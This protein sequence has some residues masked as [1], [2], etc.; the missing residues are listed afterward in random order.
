MK[1]CRI[2]GESLNKP[3]YTS[4]SPSITSVRSLSDTQIF[5]YLC[6]KCLHAQKPVLNNN[7]HY[8]DKEYK[9]SLESNDFDQ[10]YD[11]IEDNIIYRTDYQAKLVIDF[12]D[13]PHNAKVLDYGAGKATTLRK[14]LEIRPD[15]IPYIFDV[16]DKYKE[17][18]QEF[19]PKEQQSTYNIPKSWEKKFSLITA[20]FV[21]EH[22]EDPIFLLNKLTKLLTKDGFIFF[23]VPNLLTNPGDFLAVDHINH[24]STASIYKALKSAKLELVKINKNIFRGAILCI[25]KYR[26][27]HNT[28]PQNETEYFTQDIENVVRYWKYF[29][30]KLKIL[31]KKHTNIP[32]AIFGAGVYGSYIAARIKD[33]TSL[34]CFLDNSDHLINSNHMGVP[35][36]SPQNIPEDI[37]VIYSGIN[38]SISRSVFGK[39]KNSGKYKIIFFDEGATEND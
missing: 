29:D 27:D 2:C 16:S 22:T 23:T 26:D 15:I 19:T 7:F 9:I 20:H 36:I 5:V 4:Q 12:I 6:P 21:F 24:F 30:K 33:N 37:Q 25:A 39:L 18:W 3:I 28:H 32:T 10:L 17:T 1:T 8:Y 34:K 14:I 31:S 35:V 13:I 38:P 11:K